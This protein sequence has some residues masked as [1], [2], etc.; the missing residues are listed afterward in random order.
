MMTIPIVE[1][2]EF[3]SVLS[4]RSAKVSSQTAKLYHSSVGK[5]HPLH[6]DVKPTDAPSSNLTS[7]VQQVQYS[8]GGVEKM[9]KQC[10]QNCNG[11]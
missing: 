11:S 9:Y 6:P 10:K 7:K 5:Y 4:S 3:T 8:E 1:L 2:G